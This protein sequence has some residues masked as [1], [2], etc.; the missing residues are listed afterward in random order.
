MGVPRFD[1][2]SA[3]CLVLTYKEG[4]LSAIA[5]DL[6]I[7][8]T[9]FDLEVDAATHAVRAS[10]DAGSL[11]V[12]GAMHDGVLREGALSEADKHKIEHSI[13]DDVL[14]TRLHPEIRFTSSHVAP[15]GDGFHLRGELSLHGRSR[16]IAFVAH[17]EGDRLVAEVPIHQPDFGI[18]PYSAMLGALKIKPDLTVRCSVPAAALVG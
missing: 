5:H 15:E 3:E 8:V 1:P 9:R 18:K 7:R 17:R 14:H 2:T 4:L 6:Q 10:F 16:E 12:M 13:T 11:Q